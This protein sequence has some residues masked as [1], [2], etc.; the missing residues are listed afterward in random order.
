MSK[1]NRLKTT[2]SIVGIGVA[3][4]MVGCAEPTIDATKTASTAAQ[5]TIQHIQ[6]NP[7]M[8]ADQKAAALARLGSKPVPGQPAGK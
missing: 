2:V 4:F 8:P 1:L 7:N 6:D 3:A 5:S